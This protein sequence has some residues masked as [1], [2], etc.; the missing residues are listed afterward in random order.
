MATG[1]P[2]ISTVNTSAPDLILDGV[3]GFVVPIRNTEI[4]ENRLL[5]LLKNPVERLKM[6]EL[7]FKKSQEFTWE[8]FKNKLIQVLGEQ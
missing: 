7:A 8:K 3:D 4:I 1:L 2:V 5:Y 6:G